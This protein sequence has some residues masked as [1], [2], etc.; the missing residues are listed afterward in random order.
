MGVLDFINKQFI[1]VIQWTEDEDDILAFRYP[2]QDM[3]FRA[4]PG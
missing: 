3:R 2:M 1:D 4:A